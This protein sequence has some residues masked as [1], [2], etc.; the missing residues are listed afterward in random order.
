MVGGVV[1]RIGGRITVDRTRALVPATRS[2]EQRAPAVDGRDG[3]Q[4]T[5]AAVARLSGRPAEHNFADSLPPGIEDGTGD[6]PR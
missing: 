1:G 3:A 2:W 4:A 5:L 6:E